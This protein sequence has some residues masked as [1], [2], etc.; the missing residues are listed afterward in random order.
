MFKIS[1]KFSHVWFW[2]F[3]IKKRDHKIE[4]IF[5]NADKFGR[6]SIMTLWFTKSI[7]EKV[8]QSYFE[9]WKV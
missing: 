3:E 7:A 9:I 4:I 8:L 5:L 2:N 6:L 1:L